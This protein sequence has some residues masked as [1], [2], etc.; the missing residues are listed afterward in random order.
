MY[1]PKASTQRRRNGVRFTGNDV[2]VQRA[3]W[4]HFSILSLQLEEL[5][6]AFAQTHYPDV[7]TREDLA[8][9]INLTEARVQ[10]SPSF[11]LCKWVQEPTAVFH[12]FRSGD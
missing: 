1:L 12:C 8:M 11:T 9:K 7:F 5:E 3:T 2:V 4:F 10:V 6:N